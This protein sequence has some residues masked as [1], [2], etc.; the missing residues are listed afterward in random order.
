MITATRP[1]FEA[2]RPVGDDY[3]TRPIADALDWAAVARPTDAGEWYLVVFRS[4]RKAS[5]DEARL[6]WFDDRAHEEAAASPGFVH[7]FKGPLTADRGCLSFCLWDSRAEAR[8]ASGQPRHLE[9]V[10][11]I[12]ESYERYTLE[13][14][15][16]MA[17]LGG[18][19]LVVE[20]YDRP[21]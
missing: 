12:E 18:G 17:P 16:V 14:Y 6:T 4:I 5:A 2:L 10:T 1:D 19:A 11:L 8:Q 3:A 9:A 21:A 7:Y 15:R 13:F 20:P